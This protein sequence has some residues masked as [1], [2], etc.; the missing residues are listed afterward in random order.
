MEQDDVEACACATLQLEKT[1]TVVESEHAGKHVALA[2]QC[3][4]PVVGGGGMGRLKLQRLLGVEDRCDLKKMLNI[5]GFNAVTL[6]VLQG[7]VGVLRIQRRT[8]GCM[9]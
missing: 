3:E 5:H 1:K 8:R 4:L 2:K 9:G 7:F 6:K